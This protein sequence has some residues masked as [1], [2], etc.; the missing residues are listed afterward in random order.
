MTQMN[1]S[2]T[3]KQTPQHRA[4]MWLPRTMGWGKGWEFG[5]SRCKPLYTEWINSKV[6]LHSTG[7]YIQC[8]L[9]NHKG[10]ECEKSIHTHT[11]TYI[12]IHMCVCASFSVMSS[13]LW[14]HSLQPTRLLRPWDSPGKNTG[15]GCHFLL[16]GIFPTQGSNLCLSM[17]GEF[18]SY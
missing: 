9:I 5:I 8:P 7:N 13:S 10:K 18:L 3:Q 14:P 1:F 11:H 16:Q 15:A 6:L 17:G 2:M 12:L 4:D